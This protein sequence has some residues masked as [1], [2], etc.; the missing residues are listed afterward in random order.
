MDMPIMP[1][2]RRHLRLAGYEY[3]QPGPYFVTICIKERA[4]ILGSIAESVI[5]LNELGRIVTLCWQALPSHYP[6]ISLDAFAV[7]P[8]HFQGIIFVGAGSPRPS[9]GTTLSNI[10]GYFKYQSTKRINELRNSPG[11]PLWQRNFFEHVIRAD[12]SLNR[13]REYIC[14]NPERWELD[15]N[16]PGA[17]GTEEFDRWLAGIK[18]RPAVSKNQL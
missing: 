8:N 11:A 6:D 9:T 18:G 5:Q 17:R 10:I 15:R 12:S 3:S 7:M 14:T 13:I 16:N 2:R 4:C 1:S